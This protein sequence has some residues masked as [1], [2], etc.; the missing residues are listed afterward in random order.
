VTDYAQDQLSDVVYVDLPDVG[1]QLQQG[2]PF[3]EIESTKTISDLHAPVGGTVVEP[4]DSLDDGPGLVNSA[5]Y[6]GGCCSSSN[7]RTQ[8][9]S[10]PTC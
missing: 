3:G 4:N 5:P 2:Q 9:H 8:Q 7:P 1:A 6:G 10:S